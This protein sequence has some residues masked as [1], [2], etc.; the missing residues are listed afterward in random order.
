ME[1]WPVVI[2]LGAVFG[3]VAPLI[4]GLLIMEWDDATRRKETK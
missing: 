1:G 4:L 2:V 3:M